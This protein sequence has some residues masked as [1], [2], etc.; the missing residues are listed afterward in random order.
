MSDP[1]GGDRV[2]FKDHFSARSGDYARFR[3]V[4]PRALFGYLASV[5]PGHRLAWDCATGTGQAAAA[6]TDFFAYVIATDAS[7]QQIAHAV[8]SSRIG[9]VVAAAE[10]TPIRSRSVDLI[11]VAQ[12]LHWFDWE[13]FYRQVSWALKPAGVIAAW[14]Y[15][16]SRI[17]GD[18]DLVVQRYYAE[19][20]GPYWPQERRHIDQAYASIAFPFTELAT[21]DFSVTAE[22]DLNDYLGYLG[23][24]SAAK[25]FREANGYDP[26]ER[27]RDVL[28]A[29]WGAPA[30]RKVVQWPLYLRAG[31]I[32]APNSAP[33]TK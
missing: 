14:C 29:A 23:T 20:L 21:P 17:S 16:L 10:M 15:G 27:I 19:V 2:L 11:T 33:G 32:A 4:Y 28:I 9:Y 18:I 24:W 31:K 25:R 6:L 3:P 1:G 22:W 12:A 5:V 7:A 30:E 26:I 8:R 13:T